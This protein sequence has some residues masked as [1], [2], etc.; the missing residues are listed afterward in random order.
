MAAVI[1]SLQNGINP[2]IGA[3]RDDLVVADVVTVI[4]NVAATTYSWT[5]AF[6]P[7]GSA[8]A[9]SGVSTQISPGSFVIDLEGSYLVKLTVDAGL[10][11]ESTQ[12]VRLRYL[13]TKYGLHLVSAGERRDTTGIIPV[14]VSVEGW[15]NE[16]NANLQMLELYAG[17]V[18][19]ADES[20]SLGQQTT[21]DFV[22]GGVAATSA[23]GVATI[24]I[25]GGFGTPLLV[26]ATPH[27]VAVTAG[28]LLVNVAGVA[29]INLPAIATYTGPGLRIKD[30]SGNAFAN[31]IT[32]NANGAETIDG[33][34]FIKL[35][36]NYASV[37]LVPLGTEWSTL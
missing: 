31:N 1:Q 5:L 29:V 12:Y 35:L 26:V 15:A 9:F 23:L 8:A 36:S 16:Q 13:T 6:A 14:D 20:I 30:R 17:T 18:T 28:I 37:D 21:L 7:D 24:T 32:I 34:A 3:S 10:S 22:G 25:L 19:V 4:A 27:A 2:I 11:S 33:A